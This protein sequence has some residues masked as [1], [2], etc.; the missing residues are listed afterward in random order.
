[1]KGCAYSGS[2]RAG[3]STHFWGGLLRNP[4][5]ALFLTVLLST[6]V[7]HAQ[8]ASGGG[9]TPTMQL[10]PVKIDIKA[11]FEVEFNDNINFA[12]TGRESD[13]IL[14]PGLTLGADD[15]LNDNNTVSLQLGIA[16]EEYLIHPA[17]SSYT[18]FAE[19]SPDSKLAYT[20]RL[21]PFTFSI[22]DSFNYSVEPTDALDFDPATGQII[23]SVQA[24]GRFLNQIGVTGDWDMNRVVLYGGLYRYDVIPQDAEFDFIRRWQYTA[25]VGARYDINPA[26]QAKIDA[27]YTLNYYRMPL[28]NNSASWYVGGT[29]SGAVGKTITMNGTI[30]FTGYDFES[31]GTNG[32]SSQ[33]STFVGAF[34]VSQKLS[35]NLQ[36]TFTLTRSSNFGYVSNTITVDRVDYKIE[37]QHF[38]FP[39][40]VGV[41]ELYYE[42]GADSGGLAP[43]TY[44]KYAISPSVNYKLSK[45]AEW[46]ASYQF[47]QKFSNFNER[48][49]YQNQ[50]ILGFRY[51]F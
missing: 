41:L 16:W 33:P 28:E 48:T 40:M 22:Y 10:G 26:L 36:H 37:M 23:T 34:S 49:Y 35:N 50:V 13:I 9:Q 31:D 46:Y 18:N 8:D 4:L 39:L 38:M 44:D 15:K 12:N 45:R 29:L 47:T 17:L 24:F 42:H 14:R 21:P 32:D 5:A 25:S 11:S 1:M 3:A 51:E 30:G 7:L 20:L 27:S 6:S 19:V 43:E 2:F